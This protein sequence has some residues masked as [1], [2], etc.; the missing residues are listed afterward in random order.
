MKKARV[1]T[2]I[3]IYIWDSRMV[4]KC[5]SD[6]TSMMLI[7]PMA[8]KDN[9]KNLAFPWTGEEDMFSV[10]LIQLS[11]KRSSALTNCIK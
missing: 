3:F 5:V 1:C 6:D 11:S 7:K 9:D 10:E 2:H 4:W 8:D